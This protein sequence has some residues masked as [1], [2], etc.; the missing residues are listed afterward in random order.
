MSAEDERGL[1]PERKR[2]PASDSTLLARLAA[3][4]WLAALGM[5]GVFAIVGDLVEAGI[6]AIVATVVFL[7]VAVLAGGQQS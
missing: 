5:A 6:I 7:I 1:L 4:G 2:R 3:A